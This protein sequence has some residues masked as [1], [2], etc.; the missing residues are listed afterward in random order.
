MASIELWVE[1]NDENDPDIY[2][3]LL[4]ENNSIE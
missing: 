4:P 3:Q 2:G 1:F